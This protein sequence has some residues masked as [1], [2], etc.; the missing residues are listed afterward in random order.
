MV[1]YTNETFS[2]YLLSDTGG[3]QINLFFHLQYAQV[4]LYLCQ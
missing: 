2:K 3:I 1:T 4:F